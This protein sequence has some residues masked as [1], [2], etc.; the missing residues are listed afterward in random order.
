MEKGKRFISMNN[1]QGTMNNFV[2]ARFIASKRVCRNARHGRV[3][4]TI[5]L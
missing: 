2:E 1:E 4:W 3:Q 5:F